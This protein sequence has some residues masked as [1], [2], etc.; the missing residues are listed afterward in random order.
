MYLLIIINKV[1]TNYIE[2]LFR[3]FI[4]SYY[5]STSS[6]TTDGSLIQPTWKT[7]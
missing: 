7:N 6:L 1:S 4:W 2:C 5:L 3:L